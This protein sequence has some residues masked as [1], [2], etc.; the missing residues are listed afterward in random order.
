MTA[1][2]LLKAGEYYVY[3]YK[4][5]FY[6]GKPVL[7]LDGVETYILYSGIMYN[8]TYEHLKPNLI[9]EKSTGE[10]IEWSVF[11]ERYQENSAESNFFENY[12]YYFENKYFAI[13]RNMKK[14]NI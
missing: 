11:N 13:D 4:G 6:E 7:E 8:V 12:K 9:I 1:F 3:G 5:L 2:G 10:Y 14:V